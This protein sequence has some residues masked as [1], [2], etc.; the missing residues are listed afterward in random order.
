[1]SLMRLGP[2][3]GNGRGAIGHMAAC[4]AGHAD[5]A[6]GGLYRRSGSAHLYL[7]LR[8]LI[9]HAVPVMVE[10]H[11]VIDVDAVGLPIAILVA[12]CGQAAQRRLVQQFKLGAAGALALAEGPVIQPNE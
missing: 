3:F 10:D 7:L 11:V 1:M 9:R 6:M 4:M 8:E 12:F 5:A 2:M